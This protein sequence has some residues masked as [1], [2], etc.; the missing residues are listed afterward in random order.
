MADYVTV[1]YAAVM[2]N[3]GSGQYISSQGTYVSREVINRVMAALMS[4]DE[5]E[6]MAAVSILTNEVPHFWQSG[7]EV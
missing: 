4:G 6:R 3:S 7:G 1:P 2:S 5:D